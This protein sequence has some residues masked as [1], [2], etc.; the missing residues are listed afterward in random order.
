VNRPRSLAVFTVLTLCLIAPA[1][2]QRSLSFDEVYAGRAN[3]G[4]GVAVTGITSL[5]Q[6][7]VAQ[8]LLAELVAVNLL[9]MTDVGLVDRR[10]SKYVVQQS[11]AGVEPFASTT[12]RG[13]GYAVTGAVT[14]M[15]N[16][17]QLTVRLMEVA[18]G[19]VVGHTTTRLDANSSEPVALARSLA[20][21][22]RGLLI[23]AGLV[24]A[25]LANADNLPPAERA[26]QADAVA[27]FTE[28]LRLDLGGRWVD[29]AAA[30]RRAADMADGA[31]PEAADA[32]TRADRLAAWAAGGCAP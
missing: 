9:L 31:F 19:R 27:T 30:Y 16:S 6:D 7:G 10:R 2:A 29:A 1:R 23:D 32:A 4:V 28:A 17:A 22:A 13:A 5:M 24:G 8:D 18:D 21:L 3:T 12:F 25:G 11:G 20:A 26:V 15:G 14:V